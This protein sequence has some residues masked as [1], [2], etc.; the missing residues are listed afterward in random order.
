M[1]Y[2]RRYPLRSNKDKDS[3]ASLGDEEGSKI[4]KRRYTGNNVNVKRREIIEV[5]NDAS[6][7][8]KSAGGNNSNFFLTS[9][10]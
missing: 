9:I 2:K 6:L 5:D 3:H 10:N 8:G 7:P 4:V 1:S